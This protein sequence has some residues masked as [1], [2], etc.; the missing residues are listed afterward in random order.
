MV[1]NSV[2][3]LTGIKLIFLIHESYGEFFLHDPELSSQ[4]CQTGKFVRSQVSEGSYLY[5]E[6]IVA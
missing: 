3:D 1:F 2:L 4:T 6:I 5:Y